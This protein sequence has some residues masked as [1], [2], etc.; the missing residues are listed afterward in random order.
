MAGLPLSLLVRRLDGRLSAAPHGG[1]DGQLL[2]CF[3]TA[4]EEEAF[5]ALLQRYGPMVLHVC[6]RVLPERHDA[7]DAFQATFLLLLKK[8]STIRKRESV[9]SWLHGTAYRLAVHLRRQSTRRKVREQK[10]GRSAPPTREPGYEAAWRELQGVLDEELARLPDRYRAPLLLCY[11]QGKT[12]EEAARQLG[13]PLG[14]VR[15]RVARARDALRERLARRGLAIPAVLFGAALATQPAGAA[16]PASLAKATLDAVLGVAAGRPA[17]G[18]VSA[19][20]TALAEGALTTMTTAKLFLGLALLLSAGTLACL[21]GFN[22]APGAGATDERADPPPAA[23]KAPERE[24]PPIDRDPLGDPLPPGTRARLGTN[25]LFPGTFGLPV[26][27]PDGK[28]VVTSDRRGGLHFWDVTSGRELRRLDP[29]TLLS[30]Q[31]GA[32]AP[33]QM[34]FIHEGRQIVTLHAQTEVHVRDAATGKLVRKFERAPETGGY[35]SFAVSPDGKYLAV[36]SVNQPQSSKVLVY[37]VE[38]GVSLPPFAPVRDGV[39]IFGGGP[40]C[41]A[42][43]PDGKHAAVAP[44]DGSIRL[45]EVATGKEE[46]KFD[47]HRSE[48]GALAFSPDGKAFASVGPDG[49]IRLWDVATGEQTRN[50]EPR[51]LRRTFAPDGLAF[52][53]GGKRLVLTGSGVVRAWRVETGQEVLLRGPELSADAQVGAVNGINAGNGA[54]NQLTAL[55]GLSPDGKVLATGLPGVRMR[56]HDPATG[57]EMFPYGGHEGLLQS[58]AISSSGVVAT[59]GADRTVRLWDGRTG[60]QLHVLRG[61]ISPVNILAFSPDGKR[62][63]SAGAG[64]RVISLWD[65]DTGREVRQLRSTGFVGSLTFLADGK[66]LLGTGVETVWDTDTGQVLRQV[67]G[68]VSFLSAVAPEAGLMAAF[69]FIIPTPEKRAETEQGR[70]PRKIVLIDTATGND[71]RSVE[72]ALDG[73]DVQQGVMPNALAFSPE[74]RTLLA[75][76]PDQDGQMALFDLASGRQLRLLARTR[77]ELGT[78]PPQEGRPQLGPFYLPDGRSVVYS[79]TVGRIHLLEV[80][81]SQ[82]RCSFDPGQGGLATMALSADGKTVVTGGNDGTALVWDVGALIGQGRPGSTGEDLDALW[83]DLHGDAP[84]AAHAIRLLAAA[85]ARSV[86]YL[87]GKVR[88][89]VPPDLVRIG[90]RIEELDSK[91]MQVRKDAEEEL[92]KAGFVARPSLEKALAA[93]PSLNVAQRI[94]AL[95]RKLEGAPLP[96]DT[97]RDLRA[98]E[99]LE[100]AGTPDARKLIRKLTEGAESDPLTVEAKDALERLKRRPISGG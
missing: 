83:G 100:A 51:G 39:A 34:A 53:D 65:V 14:T 1:S 22:R 71:V 76:Y 92:A 64:D 48:V 81:S 61:H 31:Q 82:D 24:A 84:A 59:G 78:D 91:D 80:A 88:P 94:E 77:V 15:S 72:V 46:R 87:A 98:L 55:Q 97:V 18:L 17:V 89:A 40:Q 70:P 26:F 86:P 85:P 60:K 69:R 47:G 42:F 30:R 57:Q 44:G 68:A 4:R 99:A 52:A 27:T 38:T 10:S 19:Q 67:K 54:N 5:G 9:A 95:L 12:Q 66:Q 3:V 29:P 23:V 73:N 50:W 79:D 35:R 33:S 74:G 49:F 93:K 28:A 32:G 11:F 7:E 36:P 6:R 96:A 45:W 90:K 16:V 56:L 13:W 20:A 2:E 21:A 75:R 8:A 63:V 41:L 58:V 43:A 62:L 25:R 37:D